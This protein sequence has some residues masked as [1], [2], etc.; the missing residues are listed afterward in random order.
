MLFF[1]LDYGD[2][3]GVESGSESAPRKYTVARENPGNH[4]GTVKKQR[5]RKRRDW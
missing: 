5:N 4:S 2:E 3:A 1:F